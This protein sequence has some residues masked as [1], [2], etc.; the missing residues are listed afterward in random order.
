M[1]LGEDI[2]GASGNAP[3]FRVANA[4]ELGLTAPDNRKGDAVRTIVRSLSG[5]QKE[6]LVSS[7]RAGQTWRL[8]SDEG[9]YLSG[10]DAAPCPLAFL[11]TGMV[12]AYMNE[13]TALAAQQGVALRKLRLIQN[14]YTR[15]R[16]PCGSGRW[17]VGRCRWSWRLRSIATS[18]MRPCRSF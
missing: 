5:F 12:S 17:L 3:F 9:A 15:C 6:A 7:A 10:H 16:A 2:I 8:V 11:T 13:I 1:K 14:N 4:G 18:K